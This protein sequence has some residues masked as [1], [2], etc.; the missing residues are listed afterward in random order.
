M[1]KTT[2]YTTFA[3]GELESRLREL[4]PHGALYSAGNSERTAT[5]R[6]LKS[7]SFAVSLPDGTEGS[8]CYERLG[9]KFHRF[10]YTYEDGTV[11]PHQIV[12][13]ALPN[14]PQSLE[15]EGQSRTEAC[16]RDAV[17]YER[18]EYFCRASEPSDGSRKQRPEMFSDESQG[19]QRAGRALRCLSGLRRIVSA[20]SQC[21]IPLSG[22]SQCGMEGVEPP[23]HDRRL[24]QSAR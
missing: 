23:Q 1:A 4:S 15:Q 12:W 19:R 21:G 3:P 11:L 22:A 5:G 18:R 17:E 7:H 20:A 16:F 6:F 14:D 24:L 9:P 13:E 8:C 2:R 10:I